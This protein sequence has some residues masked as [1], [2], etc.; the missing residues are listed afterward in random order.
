M[1]ASTK[2]IEDF[3]V[4]TGCEAVFF[5]QVGANIFL[6]FKLGVDKTGENGVAISDNKGNQIVINKTNF[7]QIA[8]LVEKTL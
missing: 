5:T 1:D 6:G 8:Q 7:L 2:I 3:E 4:A